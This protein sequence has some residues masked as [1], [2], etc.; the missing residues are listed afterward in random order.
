MILQLLPL[1]LTVSFHEHL[2][3][4]V[5]VSWVRLSLVHALKVEIRHSIVF[6]VASYIDNLKKDVNKKN[7]IEVQKENTEYI[8]VYRVPVKFYV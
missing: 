7:N 6:G 1:L 4:G 2:K 3:K 5:P 8:T